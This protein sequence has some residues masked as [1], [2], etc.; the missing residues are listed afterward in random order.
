M[1]RNPCYVCGQQLLFDDG[2]LCRIN[3]SIILLHP[4]SLLYTQIHARK[5]M[6]K[7]TITIQELDE[8]AAKDSQPPSLASSRHNS[9]TY[10]KSSSTRHSCEA[11]T[12]PFYS[13]HSPNHSLD[14]TP[15]TRSTEH[16]RTTIDPDTPPLHREDKP[17]KKRNMLDERKRDYSLWLSRMMG[18]QL[19]SGL[20]EKDKASGSS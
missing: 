1:S 10:S 15:S 8:A 4:L 20:G 14:A 16:S 19:V 2:L 7:S 17:R 11:N 6:D 18:K 12:S 5:N 9:S 13:V 3:I